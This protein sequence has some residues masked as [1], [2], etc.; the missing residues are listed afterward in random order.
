[1]R[2]AMLSTLSDFARISTNTYVLA[3]ALL[4]YLCWNKYAQG[5]NTIPGKYPWATSPCY[6]SAKTR[7][8]SLWLKKHTVELEAS[9]DPKY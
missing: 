6:I 3:A 9:K 4:I 8:E 1:M 5:L 2:E 7:L